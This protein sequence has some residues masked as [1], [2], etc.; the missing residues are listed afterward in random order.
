MSTERIDTGRVK[1]PGHT[2]SPVV[3]DASNEELETC[4]QDDM[5]HIRYYAESWGIDIPDDGSLPDDLHD[6]LAR[7]EYNNIRSVERASLRV[8]AANQELSDRATQE[9]ER[10][11]AEAA[12]ARSAL[13]SLLV[14]G[15]AYLDELRKFAD[16]M[17]PAQDRLRQFVSDVHTVVGAGA[18]LQHFDRT[19]R[20]IE[21]AAQALEKPAPKMAKAPKGAPTQG[22]IED[23]LGVIRGLSD[24][25]SRSFPTPPRQ[26][27]KVEEEAKKIRG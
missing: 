11:A 8:A 5:E 16:E 26:L 2:F 24:G 13:E 20:A 15:V 7:S 21:T 27:N 19:Q 10:K 18:L 4:R 23:V 22:D 25:A 12:E 9:K 3:S 1:L 14:D 6:R 17:K